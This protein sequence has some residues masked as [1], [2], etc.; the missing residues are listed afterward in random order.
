MRRKNSGITLIELMI[1]VAIVGILAAVA[2]PTY[3]GYVRRANRTDAKTALLA[4]AGA[5][6]RCFTRYNSYASDDGCEVDLDVLSTEGHYRITGEPT[7][8]A[9]TLRATPQAGQTDD[10]ECGSFTLDN[11]NAKGVIVGGTVTPEV[12]ATKARKCWSK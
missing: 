11:A 6:E 5:L 4:T 2:I 12:L 1:V 9:F 3:R 10:V 8:I 7:A